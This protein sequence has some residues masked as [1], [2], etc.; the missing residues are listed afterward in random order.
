MVLLFF[1]GKFMTTFSNEDL[2]N[3]SY[4][5]YLD[6]CRLIIERNPDFL[7]KLPG[8]EQEL[9]FYRAEKKMPQKEIAKIMGVTQGAISSRLSRLVRRIQFMQRLQEY[10]L[11]NF[12]Q[13]LSPLFSPFEIDI[14]KGMLET[15]CQSETARRLNELYKDSSMNQVKVR[16]RFEK[17]M[18]KMREAH[19]PYLNLFLFIK[20]NLYMIYDL[21]LPHFGG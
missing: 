19:H 18:D 7:K 15:T 1:N 17:C 4:I 14:L 6:R 16:Y 21:R 20:K 3:D 13:V 5:N 10:D 11:S 2:V 8:F 9:Y 12:E